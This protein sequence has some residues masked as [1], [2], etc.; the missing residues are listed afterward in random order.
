MTDLA[1]PTAT[2]EPIRLSPVARAVR[3]FAR[4]AD[5]WEDLRDRAQWWFP[6]LFMLAF[7]IAIQL[8]TFDQ[9]MIPMVEQRLADA[10]SSGQLTPDKQDQLLQFYTN[11]TWGR[12]A[13]VGP[14]M[15]F[16]VIGYLL[17]ALIVWF[18]VGF[19]L[20][21]RMRFRHALEVTSWA[22]LV[23]VPQIVVFFALA[24]QQRSMLDVHLGLG[25]FVG[26]FQSEVTAP[27]K[28][29][30]GLTGFLDL[31]GPFEAWWIAVG[32]L[33]CATLSGAPRRNVVWVLVALY[34]AFGA[35]IAAVSAFFGPGS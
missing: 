2:P 8:L 25:A 31:F 7:L 3:I 10:I 21:S 12:V 9:V 14:P 15:V 17:E 23:R 34:L 35:F 28:L 20:G 26:L 5:A 27:T 29:V 18:G 22:Q 16:Q 30:R 32:V 6:F 33:G 24:A 1:P 19:V 11:S 13:L 4:P